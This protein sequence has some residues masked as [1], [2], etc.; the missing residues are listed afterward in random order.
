MQG[1]SSHTDRTFR[2]TVRSGQKDSH[3]QDHEHEDAKDVLAD[4]SWAVVLS[5]AAA[6]VLRFSEERDSAVLARFMRL[7]VIDPE[8]AY[9]RRGIEAAGRWLRETGN[10]VLRVPYTVVTPEDWGGVGGYPLG[11]W[12]ADQRRAYTTGTL[13]AG[14]V[15]ELEKLGMVWS[16]QDAAWADGIAVAKEYATVHGHFLP[17]TTA[18]WDGHPIGVWAKNARAAARRARENEELRA[19]GLPVSSAAG[20]MNQ[21]RRDELDA[22]DPGWCPAWDTAWQRCYRLVHNHVQAGGTLP[23]PAGDVVVQG[24]DLGRWVAAQRF[25]WDSSWLHS[26]GSWRTPSSSHRPRTRSGR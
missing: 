6:G 17:P 10:R 26:S 16:E 5:R 3:D 2:C 15:A 25:G 23:E 18:V 20:V 12:I 7:R 22:I 1:A 9:W 21:A 11:Q 19:A 14:R 4:G 13:E 24:E 8:D